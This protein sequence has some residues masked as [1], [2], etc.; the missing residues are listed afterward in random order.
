MFQRAV[1]ALVL[2]ALPL[3]AAALETDD[4]LALVA[5][6]LAVAAVSEVTDIPT[7]DLI[8][9]VTLLNEANVPPAQFVEVVRYSP[10]AL[11][12]D[13]EPAFDDVLRA[14]IAEGIAGPALVPMIEQHYIS[15]GLPDVDLDAPRVRTVATESFVPDVVTTRVAEVRAKTHPHGG[16]PGQLKKVAGVQTGAEIVHGRKPGRAPAVANSNRRKVREVHVAHEAKVKHEAKAKREV[17]VAR[18]VK[19]AHEP[20]VHG[21]AGKVDHGNGN[22]NA[23]NGNGNG[24]GKGHGKGKG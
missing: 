23:G 12:S 5:M 22:G 7:N 3:R 17:H 24:H 14:Q 9:M 13:T 10:V 6:P 16:P 2:A 20:K 21:N 4:L 11:M 8:D 15:L 18:E 1:L 19:V